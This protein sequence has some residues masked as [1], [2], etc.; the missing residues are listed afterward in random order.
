MGP[1]WLRP[2]DD[3]DHPA[4]IELSRAVYNGRH[5]SA[6]ECR[7]AAMTLDGEQRR[8]SRYVALDPGTGAVT[9]YGGVE[10]EPWLAHQRRCRL[11]LLVHPERQG[12]GLG[13][14]LARKL[15]GEAGRLDARAAVSKVLDDHAAS[16]EFLA[17]RGFAERERSWNL[18]L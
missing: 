9:G 4:V 1:C 18:R 5:E 16:L 14:T 3:R 7:H 8:G 11:E 6:D 13:R 12:Q 2:Y 10:T 17:R 15:L